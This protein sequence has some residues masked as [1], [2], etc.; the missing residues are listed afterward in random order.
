MSATCSALERAFKASRSTTFTSLSTSGSAAGLLLRAGSAAV[1]LPGEDGLDSLGVVEN[2]CFSGVHRGPTRM[3]V[4]EHL[5]ITT[6]CSQLRQHRLQL[7]LQPLDAPAQH[8]NIFTHVREHG[9][10]GLVLVHASV[11]PH[12]VVNHAHVQAAFGASQAQA[13]LLGAPLAR[14]T[15]QLAC[16][17]GEV[18]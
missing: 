2:A 8:Q 16:M 4:D 18:G 9:L 17:E 15:Q 3:E 6:T 1:V 7:C 5:G 14:R 11:C 13:V 10:G 12:P